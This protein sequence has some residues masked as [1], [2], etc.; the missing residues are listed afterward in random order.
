MVSIKSRMLL[1]LSNISNIKKVKIYE[2][3]KANIVEIR[4]T[5]K[6]SVMLTSKLRCMLTGEHLKIN[7]EESNIMTNNFLFFYITYI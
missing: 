7:N 3:N 2:V 4:G 1:L 5:N 6:A